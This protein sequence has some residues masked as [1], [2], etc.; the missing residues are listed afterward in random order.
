MQPTSLPSPRG[1]KRCRERRCLLCQ[2]TAASQAAIRAGLLLNFVSGAQTSVRQRVKADLLAEGGAAPAGW[3]FPAEPPPTPARLQR[4]TAFMNGASPP[5]MAW[6]VPVTWAAATHS[7]RT[8]PPRAR[9]PGTGRHGLFPSSTL[10]LT[11]T[12]VETPHI[13]AE[14]EEMEV[15]VLEMEV[16]F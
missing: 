9:C 3:G 12:H 11:R 4:D 7:S 5:F 14:K 2:R 13:K 1:S 15:L 8:E 10:N 6:R 16:G